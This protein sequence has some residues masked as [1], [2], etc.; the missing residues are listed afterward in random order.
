M[1]LDCEVEL[2]PTGRVSIK[3]FAN[4]KF[5]K[6]NTLQLKGIA[7]IFLLYHHLFNSPSMYQNFEVSFFPL[8]ERL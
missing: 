3:K 6:E 4:M 1:T 5:T 8:T 2:Y 7:V